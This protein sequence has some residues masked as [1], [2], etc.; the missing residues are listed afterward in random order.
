MQA[1]VATWT[2]LGAH[3]AICCWC[4]MFKPP[5]RPPLTLSR[6]VLPNTVGGMDT[7]SGVFVQLC[8][9]IHP[10]TDTDSPAVWH[11]R[12]DINSPLLLTLFYYCNMYVH[13]HCKLICVHLW[14]PPRLP[15][16]GCCQDECFCI[17]C[18]SPLSICGGMYVYVYMCTA[19]RC[20]MNHWWVSSWTPS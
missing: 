3:Q 15:W 8:V 6:A 20:K 18:E 9:N 5:K 17:R 2:L 4:K 14:T 7:S 1:C 10:T 12:P 13:T 16:K 11:P 19:H